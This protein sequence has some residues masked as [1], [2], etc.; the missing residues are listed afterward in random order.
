MW[1]VAPRPGRGGALCA[2][3]N[4]EQSVQA[5]RDKPSTATEN[6]AP[7]WATKKSLSKETKHPSL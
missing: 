2:P 5:R 4:G 1:G 3:E 6:G 7:L